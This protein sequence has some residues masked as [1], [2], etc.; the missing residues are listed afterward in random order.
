MNRIEYE[1]DLSRN[2]RLNALRESSNVEDRQAYLDHMSTN[3]VS[4]PSFDIH[5]GNTIIDESEHAARLNI[6]KLFEKGF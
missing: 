2:M 4:E 5:G 1:D 3:K 6:Q